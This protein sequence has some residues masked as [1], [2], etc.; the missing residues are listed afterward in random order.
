M[1]ARLNAQ[2]C[3]LVMRLNEV[4]HLHAGVPLLHGVSMWHA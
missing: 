2:A 4:H 3:I 1:F